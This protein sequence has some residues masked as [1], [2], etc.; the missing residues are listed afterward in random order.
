M[1][2]RG[3]SGWIRRHVELGPTALL[4]LV[5]FSIW[6][7]V[8]VAVEVGEGDTLAFDRTVLLALRVAGDPA[9]PIGPPWMEELARDVTALGG[10]GVLTFLTFAAAGFLWLQRKHASVVFLLGAVGSGIAVSSLA[11]AFFD[12]SRPDLV[13]H[14][15]YVHS[16]SFPSGHSMMSAVVYLTLAAIMARTLPRRVLRV[17]VMTLAIVLTVSVGISR[18]Y[19]GVHWPTDVLAGWAGG[20]AWALGCAVVALALERRGQIEPEAETDTPVPH[21]PPPAA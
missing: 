15:A 9:D 19:L 1:N 14:G 5:A 20:A 6:I 17:Y 11:K 8:G 12:R 7:F 16:A 2:R 3:I 21:D 10:V 13:P 4:L 18:V